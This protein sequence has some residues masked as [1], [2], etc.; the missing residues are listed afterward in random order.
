[1]K[2]DVMNHTA[3]PVYDEIISFG[4]A[5]F[6][7]VDLTIEGPNAVNIDPEKIWSMQ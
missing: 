5:R 7:F 3:K 6:E 4:K 2:I 1:M